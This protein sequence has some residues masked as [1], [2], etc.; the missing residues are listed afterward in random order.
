MTKTF[1]E[2]WKDQIGSLVEIRLENG[3]PKLGLLIKVESSKKSLWLYPDYKWCFHSRHERW[4]APSH[5][6]KMILVSILSGDFM[7]SFVLV[8]EDISSAVVGKV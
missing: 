4:K 6:R 7:E 2:K 1:K 5:Q 3:D 8:K